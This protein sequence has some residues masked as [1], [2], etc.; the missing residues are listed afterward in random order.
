[1]AAYLGPTERRWYEPDFTYERWARLT[2]ET[3]AFCRDDGSGKI[4]SIVEATEKVVPAMEVE[5]RLAI[6]RTIIDRDRYRS[7]ALNV[8]D[9]V[10]RASRDSDEPAAEKSER[11]LT[12]SGIV[13]SYDPSLGRDYYRSAV[14]AAEGLDDDVVSLL[15]LEAHLAELTKG[16]SLPNGP[17][18]AEKLAG[19]IV[20]YRPFVS[21]VERLP[22]FR[23]A[24]ATAVLNPPSGLA[25]LP[26]W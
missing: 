18:L 11:L 12:L 4:I 3:I 1:L 7:L 19:A 22:W 14:E 8:L 20:D 17:E 6:G 15:A 5:I 25:L 16:S 26:R 2:C 21:D 10:A 24:S 9:E 23:V 13:A